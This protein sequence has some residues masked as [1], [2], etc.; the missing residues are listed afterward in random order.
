MFA[1]SVSHTTRLP[2]VGEVNGVDYHFV[3]SDFFESCHPSYFVESAYVH[4]N[5]Y[6]TSMKAVEDVVREGK[7]CVLDLDVQGVKSVKRIK[8]EEGGVGRGREIF[9]DAKFVF[10]TPPDIETLESR[11]LNRGSESASTLAIRLGNASDEI[12]YGLT[13]GNFDEVVVNDTVEKAT[14]E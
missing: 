14:E 12:K 2:R 4:G 3:G 10:I 1:F 8:D 13:E 7:V 6:G 9:K 11:L 5:N